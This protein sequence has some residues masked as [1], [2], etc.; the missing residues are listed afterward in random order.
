MWSPY[1]QLKWIYTRACFEEEEKEE[2]EQKKKKKK[3]PRLLK[4]TFFKVVA[5]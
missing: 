2:R 4:E 5:A 3:Y 1:T